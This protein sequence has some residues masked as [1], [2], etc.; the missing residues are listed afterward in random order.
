MVVNGSIHFIGSIFGWSR[1]GTIKRIGLKSEHSPLPMSKFLPIPPYMC[2]PRP[3]SHLWSRKC[4]AN[5]LL[6]CNNSEY[7]DISRRAPSRRLSRRPTW[8]GFFMKF[9]VS[10]NLNSLPNPGRVTSQTVKRSATNVLRGCEKFAPA[11]A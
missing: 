8:V 9:G 7:Q 2:H 5:I 3:C 6:S 10:Q 1:R 11:L 4:C